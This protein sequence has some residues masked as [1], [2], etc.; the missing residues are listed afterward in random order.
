MKAVAEIIEIAGG[1]D[2]GD[3][4]EVPS[5]NIFEPPLFIEFVGDHFDHDHRGD[6]TGDP[7]AAVIVSWGNETSADF[8]DPFVLS[9]EFRVAR[10]P[11]SG[12]SFASSHWRPVSIC[13]GIGIAFPVPAEIWQ[14]EPVP[15]GGPNIL[16]PALRYQEDVTGF[17]GRWDELIR[18]RHL[19]VAKQKVLDGESLLWDDSDLEAEDD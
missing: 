15:I 3:I 18:K 4:I 5:G 12:K 8:S 11:D 10:H 13:P 1:L 7:Y 17:L 14:A 16:N 6:L 9:V 2:K 19:E